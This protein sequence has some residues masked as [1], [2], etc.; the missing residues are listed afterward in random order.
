MQ[1]DWWEEAGRLGN[2]FNRELL[3]PQASTL[4]PLTSSRAL[5]RDE[6]AGLLGT[7]N[8]AQP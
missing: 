2:M 6:P 3:L 5:V 7:S 4:S 1:L 8:A